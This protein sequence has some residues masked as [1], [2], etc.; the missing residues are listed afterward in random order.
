MGVIANNDGEM[1]A[2]W[3]CQEG[4]GGHEG[5]LMVT[6]GR[7]FLVILVYGR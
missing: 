7:V 3:A 2:S 1:G 4:R 6:L 5:I